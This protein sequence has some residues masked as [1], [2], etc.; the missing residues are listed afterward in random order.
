MWLVNGKKNIGECRLKKAGGVADSWYESPFCLMLQ[1]SPYLAYSNSNILNSYLNSATPGL[2]S[3][4]GIWLSPI[5]EVWTNEVHAVSSIQNQS[6]Y[7]LANQSSQSGE[8]AH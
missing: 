4:E 3:R 2:L 8:N 6:D 7:G 1:N 5:Q